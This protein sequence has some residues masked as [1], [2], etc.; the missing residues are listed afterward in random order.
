MADIDGEDPKEYRW[1]TG[2]EKTWYIWSYFS[3]IIAKCLICS[4]LGSQGS[5]KG[6]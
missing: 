5:Y 4:R 3:E 2:Y 6:R 1:E